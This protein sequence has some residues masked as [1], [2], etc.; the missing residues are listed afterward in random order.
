MPQML[1]IFAPNNEEKHLSSAPPSKAYVFI[2]HRHIS[3]FR[4]E[5][6]LGVRGGSGGSGPAVPGRGPAADFGRAPVGSAGRAS[7]STRSR[8]PNSETQRTVKTK[9]M[10]P[11]QSCRDRHKEPDSH[12]KLSRFPVILCL[13]KLSVETLSFRLCLS[14]ALHRTFFF[15]SPLIKATFKGKAKFPQ[16]RGLWRSDDT[17]LEPRTRSISKVSVMGIK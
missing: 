9:Q 11:R 4:H 5:V 17:E 14:S 3:T 2:T 13:Y 15:L 6:Y 16:S 10:R 1:I 12:M 7:R 8:G